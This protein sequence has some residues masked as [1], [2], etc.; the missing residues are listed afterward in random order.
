LGLSHS[1]SVE[2]SIHQTT[3]TS[4][5]KITPSNK[6][7]PALKCNKKKEFCFILKKKKEKRKQNWRFS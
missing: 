6:P 3:I 2:K 4:A 5:A 1:V 7:L